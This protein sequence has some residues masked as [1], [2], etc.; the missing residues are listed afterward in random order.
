MYIFG[1]PKSLFTAKWLFVW[2]T[3]NLQNEH[4]NSNP[5]IQCYIVK[6]TSRHQELECPDVLMK[7]QLFQMKRGIE[8]K[9]FFR[10]CT[11]DSIRIPSKKLDH[12][13]GLNY[14][15][16]GSLPV[17]PNTVHGQ[18]TSVLDSK[19]YQSNVTQYFRRTLIL[20]PTRYCTLI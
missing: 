17:Y 20:S 1:H 5:W 19:C 11:W 9:L 7:C 10:W 15:I 12:R 13:Y 8:R 16:Y 6:G 2:P 18:C 4:S 14:A 3:E